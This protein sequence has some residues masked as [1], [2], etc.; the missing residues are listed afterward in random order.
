M[1]LK[2]APTYILFLMTI[3][4]MGTAVFLYTRYTRRMLGEYIGDNEPIM[5]LLQPKP[6]V[7]YKDPERLAAYELSALLILPLSTLLTIWHAISAF[8][9]CLGEK[10][11][12]PSGVALH[13][14][15]VIGYG[16]LLTLLIIRWAS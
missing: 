10:R 3:S 9:L 5:D 2:D 13:L 7:A 1:S 15:T 6:D 4:A 16:Y 12:V 8:A 14:L 11:D